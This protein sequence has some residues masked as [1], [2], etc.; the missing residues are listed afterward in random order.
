MTR[1]RFTAVNTT[2]FRTAALSALFYAILTGAML[3]IVYPLVAAQLQAQIRAGLR[4]ESS[5]LADLYDARGAG[6]LSHV[7]H[8]RSTQVLPAGDNDTDD[9]GRRYYALARPNGVILAGDLPRWP[10]GLPAS[11]WAHFYYRGR[12]VRAVVTRLPDGELLLVGQSLAIPDALGRQAVLVVILGGALALLAGLLGGAVIGANVMRRI[13]Q[14]SATAARIQAG[15][16]AERLPRGGPGE[17]ALLADAFNTMLGRIETAVLG[18]RDLATR[19]AHEMRHPLA[20]VD[21]ALTRAQHADTA[22]QVQVELRKARAEIAE[23]GRRTEALLRLA[24]LESDRERREFFRHLDLAVLISDMVELYEPSAEQQGHHLQVKAAGPLAYVGDRQLLAQAV[25]NLLDNAL[26][27]AHRGAPITIQLHRLGN[28]AIIEVN[29]PASPNPTRPA[30][31]HMAV[32]GAGLGLPIARAIAQLH[33]GRLDIQ[34][35]E[36][37]FTVRMILPLGDTSPPA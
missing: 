4:A 37:R 22:E 6:A 23:L 17:H 26:R 14:A 13:R 28:S 18:L 3:G 24:R 16:L 2:A 7:I 29:N 5:A 33:Q 36:E 10:S 8:T 25:A 19:T 1:R 12:S 27:Y 9:P 35:G 21:Q 32:P 20:R 34:R 11:G 15:H 30:T 31:D